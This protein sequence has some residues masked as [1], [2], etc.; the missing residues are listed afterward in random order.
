M[1]IEIKAPS[2]PE[3]VADGTVATWHKRPGDNCNRDELIADIETDKVVIEVNAPSAGTL[4]EIVKQEGDV[5]LSNEL[6]A[7]FEAGEVA[8]KP[9]EQNSTSQ[10]AVADAQPAATGEAI[11]SPAARKLMAESNIEP[12]QVSG[13][14]KDGRVTKEDVQ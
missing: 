12:G 7:R 14:G 13:T 10:P 1:S 11:I 5:V 8:S 6:I 9:A 2:F 4:V 3:S